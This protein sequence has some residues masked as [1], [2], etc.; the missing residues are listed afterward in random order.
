MWQGMHVCT[1]L[2]GRAKLLT[3]LIKHHVYDMKM[4]H[5]TR[6]ILTAFETS[7]SLKNVEVEAGGCDIFLVSL[8]G[9]SKLRLLS[10]FL[11]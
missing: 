2:Q 5:E 1:V 3:V 11:F 7:T 4:Q 10:L 8:R 9:E 6:T